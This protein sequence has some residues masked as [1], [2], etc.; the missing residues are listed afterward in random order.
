MTRSSSPDLKLMRPQVDSLLVAELERLVEEAKR[1]EI[2][3]FCVAVSR[4]GD[5]TSTTMHLHRRVDAVRLVGAIEC[6]KHRL[7]VRLHEG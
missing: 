1:G 7:L 5:T 3:S 6:I 4:P 2:V